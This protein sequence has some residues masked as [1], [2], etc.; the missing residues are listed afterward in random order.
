MGAGLVVATLRD[1]SGDGSAMP[2]SRGAG[3]G[4]EASQIPAE[5]WVRVLTG[6]LP[7]ARCRYNLQGLSILSVC[8]EC[9]TPVRGTILATVDPLAKELSPITM[10]TATAAGVILW[11]GSLLVAAAAVL[12]LRLE[13]V[14]RAMEGPDLVAT[15]AVRRVPGWAVAAAAVFAVAFV[16]PHA[17]ISVLNSLAAGLACAAHLP[18]AY[19]MW[20]IFNV[21]DAASATPYVA[22]DP[23]WGPVRSMLRLGCAACMAVI[24]LGIRP[25]GRLLVSRSLLMRTGRVDRQTLLVILAAVGLASLGDALRLAGPGLRT[26]QSDLIAGLGGVVIAVGS[27]LILIGL[28]GVFIDVVRLRYAIMTPPLHLDTIAPPM[29]AEPVKDGLG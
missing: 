29:D 11:A 14:V 20:Q 5:A 7:C 24:I 22:I 3:G 2:S 21:V 1:K 18:L 28:V 25:N 15:E 6:E 26:D 12:A 17:K 9:G 8:P 27:L 19:L 4:V 13:E 16:R 23:T 10:P